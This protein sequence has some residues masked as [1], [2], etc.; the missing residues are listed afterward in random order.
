MEGLLDELERLLGTLE[1]EE[2]GFLRIDGFR[3]EERRLVL[4]LHV[5]TGG[6]GEEASQLWT[7][8]CEGAVA[9]RFQS[10]IA[11]GI[12]VMTEDP[13]LWSYQHTEALLYCSGVDANEG[14]TIVGALYR[15]YREAIGEA[16]SGAD[17]WRGL[18][19]MNSLPYGSGLVANGPIPL[20]NV[21]LNTLEE[22]G[23]KASIVG[24]SPPKLW[25]GDRWIPVPSEVKLLVCGESHVIARAFSAERV[26]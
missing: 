25:D 24:D 23:I 26:E 22:M 15:A 2:A 9:Y 17:F 20:L 19:A 5:V 6:D 14:D 21:Y 18:N 13:V 8:S 4:T 1:F 11:Y 16:I 12:E 7:I 3:R 10:E